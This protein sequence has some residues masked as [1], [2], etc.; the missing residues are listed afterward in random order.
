MTKHSEIPSAQKHNRWQFSIGGMLVFT[1]SV[2]IGAAVMGSYM[3]SRRGAASQGGTGIQ[4][5]LAGG[6]MVTIIFWMLLGLL[7]Q[8]RDLR[9]MLAS[10]TSLT[11]GE[12][13]GARFEIVWRLVLTLLF[14]F[15]M[16]VALFANHGIIILIDKQVDLWFS[17]GGMIYG[18]PLKVLMGESVLFMLLLVLVS[19]VPYACRKRQP[20]L[21]LH[22]LWIIAIA[23]VLAFCLL[24]VFEGGLIMHLV[25]I[26][27]LGIDYSASIEFSSIDP[28]FYNSRTLWFFWLSLLS[29]IVV[30]MNSAI[31]AHLMLHWSMGIRK[32][33]V[34]LGLLLV[35]VIVA[36]AYVVWIYSRG[37]RDVSPFHAQYCIITPIHFWIA[38]TILLGILATVL[39]YRT[40]VERNPIVGSVHVDWRINSHKYYHEWRSLLVFLAISVILF[41]LTTYPFLHTTLNYSWSSSWKEFAQLWLGKPDNLLCLSFLLVLIHRVFA[42]RNDPRQPPVDLPQIVPARFLTIW[43]ATLA[44]MISG[45]TTLAW[46]SFALWFNPWWRGR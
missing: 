6:M 29:G 20:S 24:Q 26:A 8:V 19:S 14:G 2:A 27:T 37:L 5:G 44:V 22:W 11:P 7:Y 16:L 28:H 39:T 40:T 34:W 31:L 17:M 43:F 13:W 15:Y 42:R 1:L 35:G 9:T 12:C 38:A 32:R 10:N 18:W 41:H 46:M 3:H 36:I 45:I 25:H 30:L 21:L 33:I 23:V 4:E